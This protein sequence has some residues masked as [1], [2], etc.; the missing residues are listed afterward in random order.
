[1]AQFCV[2]HILISKQNNSKNNFMASKKFTLLAAI[3]VLFQL[4]GNAQTKTDWGWD[5]KDSSKVP[6]K[7]IPQYNEFLNNQFPYPPKPRNAWEFSIGAG[8]S[9]ISGG[10]VNPNV[11]ITGVLT[12]RKAIDNTFSARLLYAGSYNTGT[13]NSYARSIGAADYRTLTHNI[14]LDF[15]ASLN[16]ASHYR[17]NPKTNVYVLAGYNLLFANVSVKNAQGDFHRFY[18]ANSSSGLITTIGGTERNGR[19][20][21]AVLSG[22]SAGGG[23]AFKVNSK[24]NIG[25]EERLIFTTYDFLDGFRSNPGNTRND[26]MHTTTF[27]LNFNLGN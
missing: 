7:S 14:G 12:L 27:K 18:G 1:M 10:D 23:I 17:A 22:F 19:R 4:A 15:I 3:V 26:M 2:V 6:T 21:M 13:P 11:G 20:G 24:F 8:P 25:I 5:W 9:F 16:A